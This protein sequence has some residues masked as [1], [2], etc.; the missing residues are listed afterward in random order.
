MS[1]KALWSGRFDGDMDDSVLEFTSSLNI[2]R[3]LV[4]YDIM[5]SLAHV[6]MLR[7]RKIL[8]EE[9]SEEIIKGLRT[10]L[11]ELHDNELVIDSDLEDIHTNIEVSLTELIGPAGG[12]LHTGR[13]R[14][15]QVATDL[16]MYVRDA[17]LEVVNSVN[18][19]I[20][21]LVDIA[22]NTQRMIMPG[23]THMQHAQPVSVAQ[24]MMAH[25]FRLSRDADR[26]MDAFERIN[27]C[28]LGSAALA[29][30]T[31]P[32]DRK[33]T[34]D[35][36]GFRRP[37]ENS[38]DS[39]SDRDFVIEAAF[40]SS[41]LAV[42]LSSMA[43]ELVLWSSQEFGFIEMDDLCTTGSSIMPQKKNPDVAEL[44]RGRSGGVIGDLV[45]LLTM[46]K[47]LPLTYNRDMQL[48]KE[49]VMRSL[50]TVLQCTNMMSKIVA[51]MRFNEDTMLNS[52]SK[53]YINATDLADYL[54]A[55]GLPFREAHG[56]VA[57]AVR[58]CIL[59]DRGLEEL[60]LSEMKGFSD[61]IEKDVFGIL[62]IEECVERRNSFGGTSSQSVDV[63][64][65]ESLNSLM[66]REDRVRQEISLLDECWD[67]LT[68]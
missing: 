19:L 66:E 49:P 26:F 59:E 54:V 30:T 15:D 27:V 50:D 62:P 12:K 8:E 67:E 21:V 52:A 36:L 11:S 6:I 56:V 31:Y 46:M 68:G 25:S 4:F 2:D 35:L 55:K 18:L 33:L 23:F 34:S 32:I 22:Q 3:K 38:A 40:C 58:Y 39:V 65:F 41:L 10:L 13:S 53:G 45:S 7:D 29:G 47:G 51:A 17:V 24:H 9:D 37:T 5:G 60:T 20:K 1:K 14:N 43:E 61:M 44:I 42:H 48:D 57:S 16:R 64:I 63:Q 28:P